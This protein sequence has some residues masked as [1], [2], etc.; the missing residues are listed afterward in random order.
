MNG[1]DNGDVNALEARFGR[2][3]A[4]H[5]EQHALGG[6]VCVLTRQDARAIVALQGAQVLSYETAAFGDLLWLSPVARLGTGKA[7]RGGV[8]VCWPWFG[9]HPADAKKPA[10][11]F[12]RTRTWR[13]AGSAASEEAARLILEFDFEKLPAD[14]WPQRTSLQLEVTLG[15]TLSVALSTENRSRTPMELTGALHSYFRVRD[16]AAVSIHGLEGRPYIDQLAPGDLKCDP[17]PIVIRGET[18]R[19]YQEAAGPVSI[20][21]AGLA[22]RIEIASRGSRSCVVWNPGLEKAARL[23]DMGPDG[24]RHMLCVE[25]ANAGRDV[26]YLAPGARHRLV[27]QI[28]AA[29]L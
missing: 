25:T 7:L 28:S 14:L 23:A 3:G 11:G 12:V 13:V 9:P 18:D 15:D 2:T 27:T 19:I 26:V 10:H 29:R 1:F 6:V 8:P 20:V 21:D 4:V 17:A 24:E 22:R 5:F 16:V